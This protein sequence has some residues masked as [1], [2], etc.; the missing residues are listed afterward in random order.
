MHAGIVKLAPSRRE[1]IYT[2]LD[3]EYGE[4]V[5]EVQQEFRAIQIRAPLARILKA[6]AGSAGL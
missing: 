6:K 2:L 3:S 1:P 4:P 5:L